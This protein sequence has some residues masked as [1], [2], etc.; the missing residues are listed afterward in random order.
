MAARKRA[1]SVV[2]AVEAELSE[3]PEP[4]R[5]SASA[6]AALTLA[7]SLDEVP[8]EMLFRF[9]GGLVA[10]LL[11][12]M[13]E[14]RERAGVSAVSKDEEPSPVADLTARIAARGRPSRA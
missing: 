14:L 10:Q 9:Q 2:A 4:L 8:T 12:C 11:A 6:T 7:R 5:A 3:L 13:A 1:L